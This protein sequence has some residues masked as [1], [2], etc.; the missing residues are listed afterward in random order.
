MATHRIIL[1]LVAA[2]GAIAALSYIFLPHSRPAP[3]PGPDLTGQALFVDS[4]LGFTIRYPETYTTDETFKSFYH[5]PANWRENAL[6]DATGTPVLAIIRYRT[7]SD[8]SYPRY[9]DAEVRIGVSSD[10]QELAR[11]EVAA[12]EQAETPLPDV[13]LGGTPFKAFSFQSAGMMQYVKGTSYRA[14][15]EGKCFA[16]EALATGA[17]YRDDPM[18]ADDVPDET[19]DAA[20]RDLDAIVKTFAFVAP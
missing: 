2:L 14:L 4:E 1:V 13:L 20:Y 6:P 19:L 12:A 15:H 16:I 11:C 9:Y 7:E 18:S 3:S 10:P 5:L 17:S 8:H